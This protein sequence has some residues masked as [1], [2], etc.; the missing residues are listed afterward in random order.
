VDSSDDTAKAAQQTAEIAVVET[1]HAGQPMAP[2]QSEAPAR[3]SL[4]SPPPASSPATP[5]SNSAIVAPAGQATDVRASGAHRSEPVQ[6]TLIVDTADAEAEPSL[7]GELGGR[8]ETL[9]VVSAESEVK[10]PSILLSGT[11]PIDWG[12]VEHSLNR[13]FEHLEEYGRNLS[14]GYAP[15][16]LWWWLA[17][18]A[19]ATAVFELARRATQMRRV[20]PLNRQDACWLDDSA[21]LLTPRDE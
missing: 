12:S 13:F 14:Q 2:Q 11:A 20:R 7:S 5:N 6:E 8:E 4:G 17:S 9:A 15:G 18:G 3:L 1:L 10:T 16:E 21:L 19:T